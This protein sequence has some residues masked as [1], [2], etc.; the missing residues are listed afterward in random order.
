MP[1]PPVQ[2]KARGPGTWQYR[3]QEVT[4]H[5]WETGRFSGPGQAASTPAGIPARTKPHHR[6]PKSPPRPATDSRFDHKPARRPEGKQENPAV[7]PAN[8]EWPPAKPRPDHPVQQAPPQ[9]G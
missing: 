7:P 2:T 1:S 8:S 5:A 4:S 9:T 3:G 6:S